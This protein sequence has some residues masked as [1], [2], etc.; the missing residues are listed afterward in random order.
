[1]HGIR[2]VTIWQ[3]MC[4]LYNWILLSF[5]SAFLSIYTLKMAPKKVMSALKPK[6]KNIIVTME[7][8]I[9]I[10]ISAIIAS[11]REPQDSTNRFN[12][13]NKHLPVSYLFY[14]NVIKHRRNNIT[15]PH[16][17]QRISPIFARTVPL[18]SKGMAY[19]T[20]IIF[21]SYCVIFLLIAYL[22]QDVAI[23]HSFCWLFVIFM[24]ICTTTIPLQR[25]TK[26]DL[27]L[28]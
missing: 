13:D 11:Y 28:L 3:I 22:L 21:I 4:V 17:R 25:S 12:W 18:L 19:Y 15:P 24:A 23:R 6:R 9:T 1:M 7:L 20:Y 8:I 10:E 5:R 2:S 14:G 26:C 16:L 27:Y